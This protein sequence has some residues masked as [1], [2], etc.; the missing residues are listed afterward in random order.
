MKKSKDD[1]IFETINTILITI[2]F[3]IVL[4]PLLF[5]LS[6][7]ISD[8][9]LVSQ[10]KI[11]LLPKGINFNGYKRVLAYSDIWLG[12][13]NT[14]FYAITGTLISLFLT[15]T[16]AFSLSRKDFIGKNIFVVFFTVTMFF[17]GGLIP[18]YM[19]IKSLGM[20]NTVF[21]QLLPGAVSFMNIIVVRT[22]YQTSIPDSLQEAASIDGCSI[23]RLFVSII[24]PLSKPIIAVMGLFY[25]VAQW[26]S[27]F[28]AL[29]YI[30]DR[31]IFP[32]QLIL[33]EILV[34]NQINMD[35]LMNEGELE[36]IHKRVEL[37]T[38]LKYSVIVVSTL[39]VIAAYPFLQKYFIKGVMVGAIKG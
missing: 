20:R 24:L 30:S 1:I 3:V 38:L 19:V 23:F 34:V 12:Y 15:L 6:A 26:N 5:V 39:P 27:Y 8:P 11:I 21:A 9:S 22:F 16:S 32:L 4:Y 25:G 36:V 17:S 18:T 33:R 2:F 14:I 13:R 31:K 10:G 29:I 7:S 35:L 37:A 28:K